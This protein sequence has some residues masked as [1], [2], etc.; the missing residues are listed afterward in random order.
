MKNTFTSNKNK[1]K[2]GIADEYFTTYELQQLR[3]VYG[4]NTSRMTREAAI[5]WLDIIN[6]PGNF[7]KLGQKIKSKAKSLFESAKGVVSG[8]G[9]SF[10]DWGKQLSEGPLAN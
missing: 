7:K 5:M 3:T 9:K 2:K 10:N 6:T 1:Q 8:I 4:V